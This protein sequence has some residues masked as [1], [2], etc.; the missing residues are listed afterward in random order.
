MQDSKMDNIIIDGAL[1]IPYGSY[2][3]PKIISKETVPDSIRNYSQ[4][5]YTS[6]DYDSGKLGI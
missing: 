4:I 3:L 2:Y 5:H 6:G 1:H